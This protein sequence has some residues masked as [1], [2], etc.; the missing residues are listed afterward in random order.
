MAPS[1]VSCFSACLRKKN[2][3]SLRNLRFKKHLTL[4]SHFWI[5]YQ[6]K[7]KNLNA[8]KEELIH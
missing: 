1:W 8:I 7:E 4:V 5:E 6:L 2:K 3:K